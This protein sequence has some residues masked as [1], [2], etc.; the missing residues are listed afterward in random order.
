MLRPSGFIGGFVPSVQPF[1]H[2][3]AGPL[4]FPCGDRAPPIAHLLATS[5]RTK[6][7]SGAAVSSS[8]FGAATGAR[9]SAADRRAPGRDRRGCCP[10]EPA[11]AGWQIQ[12]QQI[13]R[14]ARRCR[15]RYHARISGVMTGQRCQQAAAINTDDEHFLPGACC[16]TASRWRWSASHGDKRLMARALR[17]RSGVECTP[18]EKARDSRTAPPARQVLTRGGC[19]RTFGGVE[20]PTSGGLLCRCGLGRRL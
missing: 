16:R 2:I 3:S 13:R 10:V 20:L 12:Q 5:G 8:R 6:P 19:G 4:T 17:S 18:G 7:P 11:P 14:P 9:R 15:R 1:R